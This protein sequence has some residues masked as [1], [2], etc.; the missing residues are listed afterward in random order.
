MLN[1]LL[2][3]EPEAA[4]LPPQQIPS[5]RA[6]HA[7]D[8]RLLAVAVDAS[9]ELAAMSRQ[10]QGRADALELARMRYIPDFNPSAGFTGSIEQFVGVM[11]SLP[12][13]IPAI[14]GAI[15]E[16]RAELN[17]AE[18]M[19]RQ[20]RLDRAAA[21]VAAL[22]ALRN[23]ER[24]VDI[25]EKQILPRAEQTVRIA[26]ESYSTGRLGFT[27]LI[28]MQ[29]TLLD[30]R[31]MIAEAKTAR[32]KSLAELEALAGLDIETLAPSTTQPTT[33]SKTSKTQTRP[34]STGTE[35]HKHE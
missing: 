11:I 13:T 12:T 31:L 23:S 27:D 2:A 4:L 19:Y 14:N 3:R 15:K 6:V 16:A 25:F 21:F 33:Q 32:E 20:K 1:A 8:A 9:P 28:D 5:P 18:A 35:V 10:V 17:R 34:S 29:R 24:Q 26:R 7:T 22:Y 30:V